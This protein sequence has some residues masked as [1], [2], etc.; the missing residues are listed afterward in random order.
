MTFPLPRG[1]F[2][3]PF[4]SHT[5]FL[6]C[7]SHSQSPT[8]SHLFSISMILSL[9]EYIDHVT[10]WDWMF[11]LQFT[12][13]NSSSH[14]RVLCITRLFSF[15][16]WVTVDASFPGGWVVKYLPANA[17]DAGSILWSESSP[18]GGNAYPL[19]YSFC[20]KS[21]GQRSLAG[22]SPWSHIQS[23]RTEQLST[24]THTYSMNGPRF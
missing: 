3:L 11:P 1:F 10:L 14:S 5:H 21:H 16:C 12:P 19:Q 23:D 4:L 20:G 2:P 15:C 24:Y 18:G 9:K 17:G 7:P 22:Y 13:M 6:P 8:T